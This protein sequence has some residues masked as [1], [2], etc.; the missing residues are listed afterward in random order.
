VND[1]YGHHAGDRVLVAVQERLL[2]VFRESDYLVRWGGEEFLA[3]ARDGRRDDCA[4]IAERIRAAIAGTPFSIDEGEIAMT[5]SVGFAA[6]PFV[7]SSPRA[8]TWLEVVDIA[9]HALYMAKKAGRN[10]W[11]GLAAAGNADPATIVQHL[12]VSA[13]AAIAAGCVVVVKKDAACAPVAQ[14]G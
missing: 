9:D 7:R 8:L 13:E 10:A 3:I 11:F 5:A 4:E 12:R 1:R 6:F 14:S 2:Q